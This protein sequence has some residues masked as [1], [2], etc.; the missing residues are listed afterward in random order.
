MKNV[1][2]IYEP[3]VIVDVVE[4]HCCSVCLAELAVDWNGDGVDVDAYGDVHVA[5]RMR[6]T[7]VESMLCWM[8]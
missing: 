1:N 2:L 6:V 7:F 5:V 4:E 8:N 3:A